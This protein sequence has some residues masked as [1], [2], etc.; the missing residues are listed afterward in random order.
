MYSYKNCIY[1]HSLVNL[2]TLYK[3]AAY[4]RIQRW[5]ITFTV[6]VFSWSKM[7]GA[8]PL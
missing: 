1:D 5:Y 6:F 4:K 7:D 8:G 3:H 2:T